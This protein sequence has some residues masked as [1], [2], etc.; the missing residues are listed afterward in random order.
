ML[1]KSKGQILRTAAVMHLLFHT[2]TPTSIPTEIT[3]AAMRATDCFVE[4]C[5]QHAAYLGDRGDLN[6]AIEEFKKG[7][8]PINC[9]LCHKCYF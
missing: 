7:D 2:N 6:E 5:L 3:E 4:Y 9:L 8:E 1:S